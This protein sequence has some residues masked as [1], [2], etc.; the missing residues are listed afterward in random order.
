MYYVCQPGR[1]P[2]Q[3]SHEHGGE[4]TKN[5]P[6][7]QQAPNL[8][9]HLSKRAAIK[10]KTEQA[11]R[12][13]NKHN[14]YIDTEHKSTK[15]SLCGISSRELCLTLVSMKRK[16]NTKHKLQ[17]QRHTCAHNTCT[18]SRNRILKSGVQMQ[19]AKHHKQCTQIGHGVEKNYTR[20]RQP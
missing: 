13:T 3:D 19:I 17:E 20:P 1:I 16:G 5:L 9:R 12:R 4:S 2:M 11:E 14:T 10:H 6:S 15:S 7:A 8:T 18:H